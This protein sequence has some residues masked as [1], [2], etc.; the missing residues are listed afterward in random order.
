MKSKR[1]LFKKKMNVNIVR[2]AGLNIIIILNIHSL[3]DCLN[4]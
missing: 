1:N 2:Y 4:N 3:F